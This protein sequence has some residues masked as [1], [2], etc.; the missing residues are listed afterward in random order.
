MPLP[1]ADLWK[2][3]ANQPVT[4]MDFESR[5]DMFDASM[6]AAIRE[7]GEQLQTALHEEKVAMQGSPT[8]S[9]S[10]LGT[11]FHVAGP[12]FNTT[13]R[14][15]SSQSEA[16]SSRRRSSAC[17][18]RMLLGDD[19]VRDVADISHPWMGRAPAANFAGEARRRQVSTVSFPE[20][21]ISKLI[22]AIPVAMANVL[23]PQS[24]ADVADM[25]CVGDEEERRPLVKRNA[26]DGASFGMSFAEPIRPGLYQHTFRVYSDRPDDEEETQMSAHRKKRLS[27]QIDASDGMHQEEEDKEEEVEEEEV[28]NEEK[29][30]EEEDEEENEY[31][32]PCLHRFV[33][34]DIMDH[35]TAFLVFANAATIGLSVNYLATHPGAS[36]TWWMDVCEF[37]FCCMF[38]LELSLRIMVERTAF[39][40]SPAWPLNVFDFVIVG[41]QVLDQTLRVVG[42]LKIPVPFWVLRV[43]RFIRLIRI[44]RLFRAL[45]LVHELRIIVSSVVGSIQSLLWTLL[46]LIVIIYVFSVLIAEVAVDI[47]LEGSTGPEQ[48]HYWFGSL[49]RAALTLLESVIGGVSWDEVVQLLLGHG[50]TMGASV[51]IFYIT[52]CVFCLFNVITGVFVE[53]AQRTAEDEKTLY[54]AMKI[55]HLFLGDAPALRTGRITWAEFKSKL[56]TH[57]MQEYFRAI[58]VDPSEAK[59][60]FTLLDADDSG[61]VD[62]AEIVNGCLRLRG[63]AKALELSLLMQETMRMNRIARLH[64]S[65]VEKRLIWLCNVMSERA[66]DD[67]SQAHLSTVDDPVDDRGPVR[68]LDS[69]VSR[70]SCAGHKKTIDQ[71][72]DQLAS[73]GCRSGFLPHHRGSESERLD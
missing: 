59:G 51:F 36:T 70:A 5:F 64:Q 37:F 72:A 39:F 35:I 49:P 32:R 60:L 6:R 24:N 40:T 61:A 17:A 41:M 57:E 44:V 66:S 25:Q 11:N 19:L 65:D 52:L 16:R 14:L 48:L 47:S 56:A 55:T 73:R 45:R 23:V 53:H 30:E 43:L 58:N 29:G 62:A 71:Y 63:N 1:W 9:E 28:E 3:A 4:Q 13:L 38:T 10:L 22:P 42:D 15:S 34:S 67:D 8:E 2:N 33:N 7:L 50:S 21:N 26:V 20:G 54:L 68:R 12:S 18:D 69:S 46:L 31:E 27:R